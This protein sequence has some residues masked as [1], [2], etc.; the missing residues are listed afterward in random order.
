VCRD[1]GP[2]ARFLFSLSA[3][4]VVETA[5]PGHTDTR[6]WRVRSVRTTG[7]LELHDLR[8]ARLKKEIKLWE[9]SLR[10]AAKSGLRKVL[11]NH[12]GEVISA[13]D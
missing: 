1:H 12:L 5:R 10:S 13:N 3:G 7:K 6:I 9:P 4:D 8:D 2:G 11:V